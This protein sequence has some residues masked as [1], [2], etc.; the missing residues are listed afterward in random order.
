M[1][2]ILRE[3]YNDATDLIVVLACCLLGGVAAGLFLG[4]TAAFGYA[5]FTAITGVLL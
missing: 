5:I 1:K 3:I 2:A 4:V